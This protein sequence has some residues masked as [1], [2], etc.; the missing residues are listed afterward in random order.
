MSRS[1]SPVI[2]K[3]MGKEKK[4]AKQGESTKKVREWNLNNPRICV[5]WN[6]ARCTYC[7]FSRG[8]RDCIPGSGGWAR[9]ACWALWLHVNLPF[10]FLI[11][12][13]WK[14]FSHMAQS[15][16]MRISASDGISTHLVILLF[17]WYISLFITLLKTF[18]PFCKV[19][20][21]VVFFF[22]CYVWC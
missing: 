4:R 13:I 10:F 20:P 12:T 22:I 19:F 2:S 8:L 11:K 3:E 21:V 15:N 6:Y 9:A 18:A 7:A 17:S 1:S 14:Q 16:T 5:A